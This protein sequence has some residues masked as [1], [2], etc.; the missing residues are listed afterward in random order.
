MKNQELKNKAL[1][2]L[3]ALNKIAV[4]SILNKYNI[5]PKSNSN[6]DVSIAL[7]EGLNNDYITVEIIELM[8]S[9]V[10]KDKYSNAD[11]GEYDVSGYIDAALKGISTI[12]NA[13][14]TNT[15]T[16]AEAEKQAAQ[17]A[18]NASMYNSDKV[19]GKK[20]G[21]GAIIALVFGGI[22]LLTVGTILIVK[23]AKKNN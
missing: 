6:K 13:W 8:K 21:Q 20:L 3:I 19:T 4:I 5:K 7:V 17:I 23:V 2:E 12:T 11:G 15:N 9:L 14:T 18:A 16:K 1:G 22:V 10:V